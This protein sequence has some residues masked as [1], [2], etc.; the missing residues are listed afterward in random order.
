MYVSK[1]RQKTS[2][3]LL[4]VE[5]VPAVPAIVVAALV[6]VVLAKPVPSVPSHNRLGQHQ[7]AAGF[8]E[9]AS[10]RSHYS[11]DCEVDF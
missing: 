4:G 1:S 7:L 3:L 8:A 2:Y 9:V 11:P 10:R 6:L 5:G